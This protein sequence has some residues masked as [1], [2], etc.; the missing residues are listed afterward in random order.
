MDLDVELLTLVV[1][2]CGCV[3]DVT[4]LEVLLKLLDFLLLG[5]QKDGVWEAVYFGVRFD[6]LF[7]NAIKNMVRVEIIELDAH[8]KLLSDKS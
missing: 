1:V 8:C 5:G 7:L 6:D 4:I 3:A 2:F